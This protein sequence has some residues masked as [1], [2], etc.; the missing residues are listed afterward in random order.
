MATISKEPSGA[1][2]V[3]VMLGEKRVGVRIGKVSREVAKQYRQHVQNL[4]NVRNKGVPLDVATGAWL[5]ALSDE[6]HDTLAAVGLVESRARRDVTL[7][8]LVDAF[9]QNLDV[10]ASTKRTYEQTRTALF[11]TFPRSRQLASIS[12]LEGEQWATKLRD[13]DLSAA[14]VS[15]R[16]KTARQIFARGIRWG[17]MTENPLA[18]VRAG[19]QTNK[20]RTRFVPRDVIAK[21][22]DAC[23][24]A[25]WRAIVAL[26]RFGGLRCP[27]ETL[28]LRWAD[29]DWSGKRIR[30]RSRKTEGHEGR[31]ERWCPMFPEL[32]AALQDAWDEAEAGDVHVVT[33]Y[34]GDQ[35]NLRTQLQ[36]I[37]DNAAVPTWPRLFHNM[38]ASRQSELAGAFPLADVCQWLGNS[39]TVAAAHYLQALDANFAAATEKPT[40]I[41]PTGGRGPVQNPV[42][43][44]AEVTRTGRKAN[45]PLRTEGLVVQSVAESGGN[46]RNSSMTPMGFEPMSHP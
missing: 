35:A 4:A 12:T 38:R 1:I 39:P 29:V 41:M 17:M 23:P 33:R 32:V 42:Q 27:S 8:Q 36:R 3:Q 5:N 16:I 44:G 15:R 31:D 20:A 40:G 43:N 25:E 2:R 11:E 13:S 18:H 37:I 6:A 30:V 45:K 10:K 9:F 28:A 24:D 26:S 46:V 19:V 14:T 21:V 22:L 7:G 34:R